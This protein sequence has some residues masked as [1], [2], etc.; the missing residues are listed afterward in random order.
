M[1]C[2]QQGD[3]MNENDLANLKKYVLDEIKGILEDN[4]TVNFYTSK[5]QVL[6]VCLKYLI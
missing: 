3:E 6:S 4:S 5:M 1:S 2:V